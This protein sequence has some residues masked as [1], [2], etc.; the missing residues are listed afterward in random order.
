MLIAAVRHRC[1]VKGVLAMNRKAAVAVV[2]VGVSMLLF[3]AVRTLN[4]ADAAGSDCYSGEQG[5]ST[6]TICN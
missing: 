5:P 1:N 2:I 4:R 6:P 3:V